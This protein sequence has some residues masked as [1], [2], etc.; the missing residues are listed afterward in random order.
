M[1]IG[2]GTGEG[3]SEGKGEGSGFAAKTRNYFRL[4]LW[5]LIIVQRPKKRKVCGFMNHR[6]N[7]IQ[8][9]KL[10]AVP[11]S[12]RPSFSVALWDTSRPLLQ[13]RGLP[14]VVDAINLFPKRVKSAGRLFFVFSRVP[15]T[16][17]RLT[18]HFISE[19][20]KL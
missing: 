15:D 17:T 10:L 16:G 18:C 7:S 6:T 13:Q 14:R 4:N 9:T 2:E 5:D 3:K 1:G 12:C 19:W 11:R 8:Q 20:T